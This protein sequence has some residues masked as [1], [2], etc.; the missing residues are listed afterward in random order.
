MKVFLKVKIKNLAAE[1]AIIR[2][3]ER[4]FK[5]RNNPTRLALA[6][7]RRGVV[8]R[9]ARD[10][11]LAYAYLRDRPYASVEAGKCRT[12]PNWTNV[13]RMVDKYGKR[14]VSSSDLLAWTATS[15]LVAWKES[16][17]ITEGGRQCA[18]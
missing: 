15:E 3:E 6:E 4:R 18:A 1:A 16:K 8:R 17:P 5:A 2:R 14:K 12:Q 7:H 11:L 9:E 10:S 13:A